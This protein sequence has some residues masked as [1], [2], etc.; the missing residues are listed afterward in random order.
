MKFFR[1]L[2]LIF[3][4]AS[5]VFASAYD[6]TSAPITYDRKLS[7]G[8]AFTTNTAV[9][10]TSLGYYDYLGDGFATSHDVGIYDSNGNL[11]A[12]ASLVAGTLD[13]LDGSFRYQSIAPVIL[14]AG[15]TYVLAATTVGYSD[16]WASGEA[17]NDMTGFTVDPSI[18]I[19]AN[20]ALFVYQQDDILRDP[21]NHY[22]DLTIYAGPNFEIASVDPPPPSV[23]EPA[24]ALFVAVPLALLAFVRRRRAHLR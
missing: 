15:Q 8:F 16:P 18:S 2:F 1:A 14:A 6:F 22:A 5:C 24:S 20:A 4:A 9:T 13:T 11:V 17:G 3:A 7:L 10:V 12:S 23:P 19:A 21:S